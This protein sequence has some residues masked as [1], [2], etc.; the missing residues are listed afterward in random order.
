MRTGVGALTVAAARAELGD[1]DGCEVRSAEGDWD[2][3]ADG[4][5]VAET[6]AVLFGG[7]LLH[8]LN[9]LGWSD[10]KA[11]ITSVAVRASYHVYGGIPL[12]AFTLVF[13]AFL[14]RFYQRTNRLTAIVLAHAIYDAVVLGL[15]LA[16]RR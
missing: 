7:Y 2:G 8:R 1:V 15:Y 6:L 5:G 4:V 12:V 10:R 9:Q 16:V 13:G 3:S 11:L 14:G